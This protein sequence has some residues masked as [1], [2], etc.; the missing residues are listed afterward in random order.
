MVFIPGAFYPTMVDSPQ[1]ITAL[2][3]NADNQMPKPKIVV[4]W[5][6]N[7]PENL[8]LF[9]YDRTALGI[10]KLVN[11]GPPLRE[12]TRRLSELVDW[13]ISWFGE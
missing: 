9:E 7:V 8:L 12:L 5:G 4:D 11:G 6:V 13:L 10:D 2:R 1:H 3:L